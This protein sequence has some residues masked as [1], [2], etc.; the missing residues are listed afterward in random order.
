METLRRVLFPDVDD[1]PFP[2]GNRYKRHA[3]EHPVIDL[4]QL[5]TD[6]AYP[7]A[8][9]NDGEARHEQQRTES[10]CGREFKVR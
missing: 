10:S 8:S 1:P 5:S 4:T 3:E 2:Y 7:H 9:T 6:P